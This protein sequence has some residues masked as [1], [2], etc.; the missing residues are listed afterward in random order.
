MN[1][2]TRWTRTLVL[3]VVLLTA[4]AAC[5]RGFRPQDFAN[6][7]ALF[8]GSMQEYQRGKMG[9]AILG[10]ERLTL[11]LSSRDSLLLPTY[12]FLGLA[13]EKRREYLLAAQA[14]SRL[15]DAF[16][17]DTL[18]PRAILGEGR[19]YQSLWRRYDLDADYGIKAL[20]TFRVLL[21]AFPDG[22]EAADATARIAQLEDR[23]AR[24]DYETGV[25]YLKTRK[26]Y[27]SAII[28]FQ[29]VIETY[30]STP[31]A[32]MAWVGLADAYKKLKY[33]EELQETCDE[34]RLRY[35]AANPRVREICGATPVVADT[36]SAG[37]D[38]VSRPG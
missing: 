12:Y 37:G 25:H 30:P 2:G 10:F 15:T 11:D 5:S 35:G 23:L 4:T 38:A 8:R 17:N 28:Y 14:F 32:L 13:H 26:A 24:K 21:T 7:E 22:A 16:P 18:T 34:M 36:L 20:G 29:D 9:D 33:T 1:S 31:T 19:A 3:S 27:D 6:P